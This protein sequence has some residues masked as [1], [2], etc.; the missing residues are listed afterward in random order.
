MI[1]EIEKII[2]KLK[3]TPY[4]I[5]NNLTLFAFFG[6]LLKRTVMLLRGILTQPFFL[7][8]GPL[9]FRGKRVFLT[10]KKK[11][12]LGKG[13]T[14]SD[15]SGI[16]A[17][18][19]NFVTIGDNFSLGERSFI[20]GFG[21]MTD[22]GNEITIGNNVGIAA[23]G[24]ISVRG[25]ITIGDDVII[26]PYFSLHSE[27]HNFSDRVNPIRLQGVTRKNVIIENDVWIGAKVTV[28]AGVTIKRGSVIA[29]GSVVTKDTTEYGIY[30]GVP[31]KF[32]KERQ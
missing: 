28:L 11:I 25:N 14:L 24:L 5:D 20:E 30:G 29:A 6:I 2:T 19:K 23:N 18:V 21:V 15:Y 4:I 32:I 27:N 22:L 16:N 9:F 3:G 13:V 7:E 31:A 26:G 1:K 10:G 12:K 17:N 8:S